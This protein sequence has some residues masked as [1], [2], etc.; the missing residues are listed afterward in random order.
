MLSFGYA[1]GAPPSGMWLVWDLRALLV[2]PA[3][4]LDDLQRQR[5]GLDPVIAAHVVTTPGAL[6][7]AAATVAALNVLRRRVGGGPA[8][9]G[10]GCT[11]GRHRS[12]AM[13]EHLA[14]AAQVAGWVVNVAH[15]DLHRPVLAS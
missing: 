6:E 12:V 10:W 9:I 4:T 14:V 15:R 3:H 2:D 7:V 13:A 1:H 5:T 8:V 11:G